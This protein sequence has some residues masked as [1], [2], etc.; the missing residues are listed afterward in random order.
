MNFSILLPSSKSIVIRQMMAHFVLTGDLLPLRGGECED[1]CV[2][3]RA[4]KVVAESAGRGAVVDVADCGAACRF[5][6]ALLA[7]T[8]GRWL[9]TGA[10][11]LLERPME[12]LVQPL[13]SIG[14]RISRVEEGWR[15]EGHALRAETLT[16]DA[17]QSSQFA[18]ALLLIAPEIGLRQLELAPADIP[19][20]PYLQLTRLCMP[21]PVEI[22]GLPQPQGPL[23]RSGDWSAAL[24]WYAH[25]LLH[26]EN[27]YELLDLSLTS[28]QGDAVVAE[29]FEELGVSSEET[30]RGVRIAAQRPRQNACLRLDVADH[31]DV[32]PVMAAL[33]VL[34]PADVT[35]LHTDNLR[36]KESD[37]V[38]ELA[39]QL[40]PFAEIR[41]TDN[42]L[43]V[44]G[45]ERMK[46]PQPPYAFRTCNDHRLAMAFLLFGPEARLDDLGCLR[47][48][49]PQLPDILQSDM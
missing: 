48:S 16:V 19:S 12:G 44:K 37:R 15:I 32:V 14:G 25:A 26:P 29:W 23:G 2:T 9:L 17:R 21:A 30:E 34:L 10:P 24:F 40:S 39:G 49:Y 42:S 27:S 47:K 43:C 33:A 46:W 6:M 3:H 31:P 20:K 13:S 8:P 28:A 5:V 7:V 45:K 1:V 41:R 38:G 4:L 22:P 11:R 36:Y 18:S 35:F